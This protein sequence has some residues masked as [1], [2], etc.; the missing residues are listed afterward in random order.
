MI[1]VMFTFIGLVYKHAKLE[2]LVTHMVLQQF[3]TKIKSVSPSVLNNDQPPICPYRLEWWTFCMLTISLPEV[4]GLCLLKCMETHLFRRY[5]TWDP[6]ETDWSQIKF[7]VIGKELKL[8]PIIITCVI[9]K[10]K[11]RSIMT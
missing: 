1:E 8:P 11:I 6:L 9:H 5:F 7:L 4:T 10:H 2:T 3:Q